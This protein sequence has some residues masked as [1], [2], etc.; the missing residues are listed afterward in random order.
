MTKETKT[1]AIA[2][3][4]VGAISVV[5][6]VFVNGSLNERTVK[7]GEQKKLEG[8]IDTLQ[9]KVNTHDTLA[10]E[11]ENLKVNFAQY[12]KILPSPEIATHENLMTLIQDKAERS[13]FKVTNFVLKPKGEKRGGGKGAATAPKAAFEEIEIT[14]NG[15]GTFEQLLRFL[16]SLERHES[17]IRVNSFNTSNASD[18]AVLDEEGKETW[19]LKIALNISTFRFTGGGK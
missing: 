19:P 1:T 2:A 14:M 9:K 10:A 5:F 3:G 13:E 15:E 7:E 11:L 18:E 17:F 12:I 8:E 6:L 16:N 4:L